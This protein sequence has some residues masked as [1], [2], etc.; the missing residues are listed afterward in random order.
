MILLFSLYDY[1]H[2]L[3]FPFMPT[4]QCLLFINT[5]NKCFFLLKRVRQARKSHKINLLADK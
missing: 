2:S 4:L 5:E 1:F 3:C